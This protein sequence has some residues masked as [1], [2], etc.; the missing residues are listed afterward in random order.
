MPIKNYTSKM[1]AAQSI[2]RIQE[3]LVAHGATGLLYEYEPGTGRVAALRFT[4]PIKGVTVAFSMPV[5][6]R[7]FREVLK[8]QGVKRWDDEDYCYRV[9]W[10][11]LR[12]WTD[13]QMAL[14]ETQ[15]VEMPQLFLPFA[16]SRNGRT[17][18]QEV[19]DDQFL[20]GGPSEREEG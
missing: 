20:L 1:P 16:V 15:M 5:D 8:R 14:L 17:L 3:T 12:D 7:L 11:N 9:A 2:A 4:L 19:S 6:W 18:Y 13:S 10:A